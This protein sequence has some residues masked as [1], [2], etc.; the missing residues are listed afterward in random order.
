M[1]QRAIE[2][3]CEAGDWAIVNKPAGLPVQAGA[4]VGANLESELSALWGARPYLVHRLDRDTAGC[5]LVARSSAA[6][7]R[8][9]RVLSE[10]G[11]RKIYLAIVRGIPREAAGEIKEE[12]TVH[13][14][15]RDACTRYTL[16]RR[17]GDRASLL[18]LVLD[19][20]RMHQIRI[21][22]ARLGHPV[23]GDDLHGD[24]ALNKALRKETGI[25]RLLLFAWRLE[26]AGGPSAE[27]PWPDHFAAFLRA[28]P[29]SGAS[30]GEG[31]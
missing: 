25:K 14:A 30:G 18:E 8:M 31:T 4:A 13:G 2:T 3:L 26:L 29:G 1:R 15:R 24:F 7:K 21:H 27:A 20:G 11:T 28:Y 23:L 5:L 10:D 16:R 9:G 6:A 22:L 12:I 17:F 19:T